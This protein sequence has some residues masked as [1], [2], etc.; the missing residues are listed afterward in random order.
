[1][2]AVGRAFARKVPAGSADLWKAGRPRLARLD[3]ELTE[4]CNNDCVHCSVNLPAGDEEARRRE[5]TT[6]EIKSILKEAASLGC[7]GVRFTGGEPLLREDFE[8]IYLAARGLGLRVR[9]FTNATLVTPRLAVL[10]EKTPPLE[11]ME[12]SVYGMTAGSSAAVTRNSGAYE[13]ARRGIK[14][15]VEHGVP[16]V[17]KGAVL[18]PTRDEMA[19]FEAWAKKTS[20]TNEPPSYA[21]LFDLRSRRD[22]EAKN[23]AIR[24]LRPGPQDHLRLERRRGETHA[25]ELQ[26]FLAARA[27]PQGGR[28]FPCL[29]DA[30]TVDAFGH[31]QVCLTLRHPA[32][33]YDLRE[34]SLREAVEGFLPEVREMRSADP[35]YIE[36]CGGCFLK[37]LCL[38]CPSKSWA[39]HGTLDTPVEYFCGITHAQAVWLG[40]LEEGEK[41]WT[42]ADWAGRVGRAAPGPASTEKARPALPPG[43]G[44][45]S[46]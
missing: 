17:I 34:G 26:R 46:T 38:Q 25:A 19:R 44:G 43:C 10:F 9:V 20:G 2:T 27:G 31:F 15:F 21:M 32:T 11:K 40:L 14:L 5:W 42:V 13:A 29:S 33:L 36:R 39:E 12:I 3:L 7:L 41:A 30:G 8:E 18:P 16:F 24:E 4:R 23:A 28:L 35:A 6:G 37:P 45:E 1:M 22:D